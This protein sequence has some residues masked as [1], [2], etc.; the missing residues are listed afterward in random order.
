MA[1]SST[2]RYTLKHCARM[3]P[4]IN[5]EINVND[6][7]GRCLR[8]NISCFLTNQFNPSKCDPCLTPIEGYKVKNKLS[9]AVWGERH[10]VTR[11][12]FRRAAS[13]NKLLE[14]AM[15]RFEASQGRNIWAPEAAHLNPRLAS[16]CSD[17]S[18]SQDTQAPTEMPSL[19]ALLPAETPEPI[20]GPQAPKLDPALLEVLT[21]SVLPSCR[22][23][24]RKRSQ[25]SSSS[26]A[27]SPSRLRPLQ[28]A[29]ST[30]RQPNVPFYQMLTAT[31]ASSQTTLESSLLESINS[32]MDSLG[33]RIFS[34]DSLASL[35]LDPLDSDLPS[36]TEE[37][38]CEPC[39]PVTRF[40]A[41]EASEATSEVS[42]SLSSLP[43]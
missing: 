2:F 41:S 3:D 13:A 39:R 18:P 32:A 25:G 20:P 24:R 1:A 23:Q 4:K 30:F 42:V 14:D 5:M 31:V 16:V 27:S 8:H 37:Q 26:S 40:M 22:R 21:M 7:L 34:L 12:S 17:R 29:L 11:M 36:Y 6:P 10:M 35:S 28:E 38:E 15:T 19:K 43:N 33:A 9:I